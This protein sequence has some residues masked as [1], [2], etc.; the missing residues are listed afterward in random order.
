MSSIEVKTFEKVNEPV[1]A[2]EFAG[3]WGE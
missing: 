3:V 2:C 1:E